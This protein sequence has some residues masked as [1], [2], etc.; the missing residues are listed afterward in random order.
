MRL[1]V[2]D[3]LE[4]WVAL[5]DYIPAKHK[6]QASIDYLKYLED[7][8]LDDETFEDIKGEDDTLDKAAKLVF[9]EYKEEN[10][11]EEDYE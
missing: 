10:E 2:T 7:R 11:Y 5:R 4:I 6:E 8:G 1:E 9:D 3:V